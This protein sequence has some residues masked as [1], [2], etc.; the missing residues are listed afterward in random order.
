MGRSK[1]ENECSWSRN[2]SSPTRTNL[3][4]LAQ[5]LPCICSGWETVEKSSSGSAGRGWLRRP[6]G[7]G[8]IQRDQLQV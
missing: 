8:E 7:V 2:Y 3:V 5:V 1:I 4:E 6:T